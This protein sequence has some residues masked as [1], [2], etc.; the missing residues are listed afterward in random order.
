MTLRTKRRDVTG[1]EQCLKIPVESPTSRLLMLWRLIH[2]RPQAGR[3]SKKPDL[4]KNNSLTPWPEGVK[5]GLGEKEK[6]G[7]SK[8][9]KPLTRNPT[10]KRKGSTGKKDDGSA[11]SQK[12]CAQNVCSAREIVERH[13]ND[14]RGD[15]KIKTG[16]KND[17]KN[18]VD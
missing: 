14:H 15:R 5:L 18:R 2:H 17:G 3:Q 1:N 4:G 7:E 11:E 6:R 8:R 12:T 16:S 10:N 9:P 13:Q